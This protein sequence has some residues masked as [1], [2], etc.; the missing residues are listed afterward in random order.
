MR[1]RSR[2]GREALDLRIASYASNTERQTFVRCTVQ[3]PW[4]PQFRQSVNQVYRLLKVLRV[5]SKSTG[6]IFEEQTSSGP[7]GEWVVIAA[8]GCLRTQISHWC[9]AILWVGI[10]YLVVEGMG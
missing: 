2:K 6:V 3:P 10:E 1:G 8:H 7:T 4:D 9:R 5:F